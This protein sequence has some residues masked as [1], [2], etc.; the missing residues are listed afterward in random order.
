VPGHI[1]DSPS[2]A[3]VGATTRGTTRDVSKGE[4]KAAL[5]KRAPKWGHECTATGKSPALK[6]E[7][8]EPSV[9]QMKLGEGWSH[10]VL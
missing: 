1:G 2:A 3:A 4:S 7:Q 10:V 6:G 5:A 8:G 9:E